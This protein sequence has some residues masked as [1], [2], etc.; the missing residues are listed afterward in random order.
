MNESSPWKDVT[1]WDNPLGHEVEGD[2]FEI[3]FY[4]FG[5]KLGE[6]FQ[7]KWEY[8]GNYYYY[9]WFVLDSILLEG[10]NNSIEY[11]ELVEDITLGPGESTN[12]EFPSWTPSHWQDPEYENT[13]VNYSVYAFTILEGD[14]KPIN[15][16]KLKL[17]ELYFGFLHDIEITSIDSPS[18][19]GP[20]KTYPVFILT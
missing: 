3:D 2:L 10:Y 9:N 7:I 13:W 5:D 20:G 19:N 15:D 6:A 14:Q 16:N 12:I 8:I 18:Q 1:P 17:I 11:A 4:G